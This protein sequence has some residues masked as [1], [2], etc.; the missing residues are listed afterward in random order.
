M[1]QIKITVI[2]YP[3]WQIVLIILFKW[4]LLWEQFSLRTCSCTKIL[5]D[6]GARYKKIHLKLALLLFWPIQVHWNSLNPFLKNKC[7]MKFYIC[8]PFTWEA[9]S[10]GVNCK[11]TQLPFSTISPH[12]QNLKMNS[13]IYIIC[14]TNNLFLM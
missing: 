14:K 13:K 2:L 10:H 1:K 9:F 6:T 7:V 3:Q 12:S 8:L 11:D 4:N 5:N